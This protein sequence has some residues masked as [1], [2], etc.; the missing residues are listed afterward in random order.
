M[1][2][3]EDLIANVD[4]PDAVV[5]D[6]RVGVTWTGVVSA[7]C[8]LAKTYGIPVA[9]KVRIRDAG[10]LIGKK[11]IELAEYATALGWLH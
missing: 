4:H 7:R 8:G 1:S 3:I 5:Q 2:M 9:H 6:V 11:A 10:R